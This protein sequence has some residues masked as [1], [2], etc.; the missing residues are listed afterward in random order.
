METKKIKFEHRNS[1]NSLTYE[2]SSNPK[3]YLTHFFYNNLIGIFRSCFSKEKHIL[4]RKKN[5]PT[6]KKNKK[7]FETSYL[8]NITWGYF[9]DPENNKYLFTKKKKYS[10]NREYSRLNNTPKLPNLPNLPTINEIKEENSPIP[11]I[12]RNKQS[13]SDLSHS[14]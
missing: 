11:L 9:Y 12:K 7:E 2:D 13:Y 4:T 8:E 10:K 1:N 6:V 5:Q 14:E 3:N